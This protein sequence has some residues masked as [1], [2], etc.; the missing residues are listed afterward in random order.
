MNPKSE[1][2]GPC[3]KWCKSFSINAWSFVNFMWE[4]P[5][6]QWTQTQMLGLNAV[7]A[8]DEG[9][10]VFCL[11][12]IENEILLHIWNPWITTDPIA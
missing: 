3:L 10:N 2:L 1:P 5:P 11:L 4:M 9:F 7:G 6:I 12:R 8:G